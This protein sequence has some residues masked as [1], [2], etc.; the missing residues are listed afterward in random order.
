MNNALWRQRKTGVVTALLLIVLAVVAVGL[1][2]PVLTSAQV[3]ER[4]Q[5]KFRKHAN[6][7]ANR[8]IVVLRDE[9]VDFSAREAAVAEIGDSL[10][11]AYGAQI[12]RTYKH[13]LNGYAM[14]M[15]EA[16][17]LALSQDSR[18]A[19]IEEDAEFSIEPV[20]A[21]GDAQNN[22]PWGLDRIDQRRLPLDNTYDYSATGRGVNVYVLDSGIRRTHRE[23][24]GRAVA[25]FDAIGDGQ[26]TNDCHGHGTHVAGTIGGVTYGVAK[27]VRL[28]AVRVLDC[29][30]KGSWSAAI[31]GVDWVTANHIKPAVANMSL[32]GDVFQAMDQAVKN[33]IAA[34]VT[35]VVAAMNDSK[36]ACSVSPARAEGSITVGGTTISDGRRP[37]SNYGAC[38]DIFAPGSEISSAWFTSDDAT[39]VK[40]GTSMASPHVAG[41]AAL[42][43]ETHPGASPAEVSSAIIRAATADQLSDVGPGSPNL[44]LYSKFGDDTQNPNVI[45]LTSG[46]PQTG[47]ISAPPQPGRGV[48]GAT[49]YSIRVPSGATQLQIELNGNQD[50]D[51]FARLGQL[52][53]FVNGRAQADFI[54]ET[55]SGA[56]TITVSP[57]SSPAL[58]AGVY[59][60]AIA[61]FGPGAASFTV[62]ATVT[63]G[64][65]GN[66]SF[67]ISPATRNLPAA[68]GL[69]NV[70][71][72]TNA[73]CN[74]TA[75]SNANFI[76]LLPPASG[77]G[78]GSI[79]YSVG[80]NTGAD[81]RTGTL[82]VAGQTFTLTQEGVG[83]PPPG[84]RV[85]RTGQAGGS[86]GGQVSVP[87]ELL[88]QGDENALGFSLTFDPAVLG[89]PQAALG[90]DASGA[91]LNA[92]TSQVG[93]GRL[94]LALSLPFGQKFSAGARQIV[95]VNFTIASG[96]SASFTPIGFGDQP[97]AREISDVSARALQASYAPGAV[98]LTSGFEGDVAPRPNGNGAVT[99]TDWV[100]IGRFVAGQDTPSGGEFQRAD[101]APRESR[102][103]GSLT[104]TDWVQAGRYA[105]GL[106]APAPAGGPASPSG[107][108]L[109]ARSRHT[110]AA[111][112]MNARAVRISS[113]Y[114]DRGQQSSVIIELD[115]EGDENAMGFSLDFDPARLRFVS[116]TTGMDASGATLNINTSQAAKGS[117]GLALALPAGQTIP[118]GQRQI[119][120][121]NFAVAAEG[122]AT[123]ATFSFGDQ[124]VM[125]ELSDANANSLPVSFGRRSRQ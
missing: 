60:I 64:G 83:N 34:G 113:D 99:I 38:V 112:A 48:V 22:A 108:G 19:Y 56:E 47:S 13:A 101:T 49:Q 14:E 97:I 68:G 18:V 76:N 30:N 109:M 105:A 117:I 70:N 43:L 87:I 75:T 85:V 96:A 78:A 106:D 84:N 91:T 2:K 124:P 31:A 11:A 7:I 40:S 93:S 69:G 86:L 32:G 77:S 53:A 17:A 114:F 115:A 26:N 1:I 67:A 3:R 82:T 89:N 41:V 42:Y 116:A 81:S 5:E 102:G 37:S 92:N 120:V 62:T 100:Q 29:Q 50:V 9:A 15:T 125:R 28:Y 95:V 24:Q 45:A 103:N 94:G 90:S 16:Q 46:A 44:L 107:Q 119:I 110:Q 10:A 12:E 123:T 88:A 118:A 122:E 25:A 59:Y 35:Y 39:A 72:A 73:G 36:D 58:Q 65:G 57:A 55:S 74:W 33:S 51:L 21:E 121:I 63:G 104:I 79:T 23:F 98:T 8:Y 71:V 61:N 66:C 52:I 6:A 80:A 4:A 20:T 111:V 54:S 27:N